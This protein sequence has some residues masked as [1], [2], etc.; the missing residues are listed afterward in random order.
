MKRF[1]VV[2]IIASVCLSSVLLYGQ[3]AEAS[4]GNVGVSYSQIIDDR[5]FGVT[6]RL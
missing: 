4:S 1:L 2:V 3:C 6:V 5:S